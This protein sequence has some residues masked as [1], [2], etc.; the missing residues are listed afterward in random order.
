MRDINTF[1]TIAPT[2]GREWTVTIMSKVCDMD[3][4]NC[5]FDDCKK[6]DVYRESSLYCNTTE[7]C[8]QYCRDYHKKRR[9]EARQ[10]NYCGRCF[11][12]P[13]TH[14]TYCYN[15]YLYIRRYYE[16]HKSNIREMRRNEGLC[17]VC[18]DKV[19]DGFKL[20]EKHYNI[21]CKN[22]DCP[23][24]KENIEKLK[25]RWYLQFKAGEANERKL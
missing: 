9:E 21:A 14:G 23:E 19:K 17:Y 15:C 6:N 11:K 16:S 8:R 2:V 24:C 1:L 10:K 5:K 7:H 12:F 20:C 4:F 13:A 3:C 22:L 18:G 25:K